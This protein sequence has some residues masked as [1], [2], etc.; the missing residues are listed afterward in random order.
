MF[1]P[2]LVLFVSLAVHPVRCCRLEE[3]RCHNGR[4]V[5]SGR[6]CDGN[7]DCGDL[8][9]EPD[10]CTNC[11]RTFYAEANVKTPLRMSTPYQRPLPYVCSMTFVA[12]GGQ[13][14]DRV[15]ITFLSFQIGA[16][17][18]DNHSEPT[19]P[20]GH[21]QIVEPP[22][23]TSALV[24]QQT[25]GFSQILSALKEPSRQ[26]SSLFDTSRRHPD[27]GHLCGDM[28]G[29][30][31]TFYAEGNNVTL[32]V[33]VPSKA[34]LSFSVYLTYKYV[35]K[36]PPPLS[37][38]GRTYYGNRLTNTYCD[39]VL[40]NCDRKPCVIRSPNF[41]GF[42]LRNITCHYWIRQE[43]VP[44]GRHANIVLAQANEYKISL[45]TGRSSPLSYPHVSLTEECHGDRIRVFDG[46]TTDSPLLVQ[47][48]G[49]GTLA[50]VNLFRIFLVQ[51]FFFNL[52]V[53]EVRVKCN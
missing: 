23:L 49:A 35:P 29:K 32:E 8:S 11:N 38:V 6:Y 39:R 19:C 3:F 7:N 2:L 24:S 14:G 44:R 51:R 53:S 48:C 1:P 52:N 4:C 20:K 17:E 15:Q 36:D 31:A 47:F 42:Y 28:I 25:R 30:S 37:V 46:P 12:A 43:S 13:Y 5:P 40:V 22:A 50:E 18:M 27:F 34:P 10:A 21:L 45:Y 26:L 33:V 41:P 9:D 16:L